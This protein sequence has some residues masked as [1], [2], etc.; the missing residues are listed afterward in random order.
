MCTPKEPGFFLTRDQRHPAYARRRDDEEDFQGY[1][2]LFDGANGVPIVGEA[3]TGYTHYPHRDGVPERI[4]QFNPH[5]K[6][7]YVIRDPIIRTISHYWWNVRYEGERR[8]MKK[9]ICAGSPYV[10]VSN[11]AMQLRQYLRVFPRSQIKVVLLKELQTQQL[12]VLNDIFSWLGVAA[13]SE[14]TAPD[15]F[16]NGTPRRFV[17]PKWP[18]VEKVRHSRLWSC[19]GRVVPASLRSVAKR[20]CEQSVDVSTVDSRDVTAYLR[21]MQR[22]QT[23]EL[24]ELTGRSFAQWDSL[25]ESDEFQPSAI[26]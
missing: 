20:F 23:V 15:T 26:R 19:A 24:L 3:S 25:Q 17:Y 6:F 12:S 13:I 21:P 8:P 16:L 11:Y 2:R 10:D 9:A 4:Y 1:L 22:E 7:I 5:A 14:S 18:W